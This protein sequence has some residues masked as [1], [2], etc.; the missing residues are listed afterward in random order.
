MGPTSPSPQ[1]SN[2]EILKNVSARD[3]QTGDNTQIIN[4]YNY[5]APPPLLTSTPSNIP[6]LGA[7]TFVGRR[8]E[9]EQIHHLLQ[10]DMQVAVSAIAGMGGVGKTELAVQYTRIYRNDYSAGQGWFSARTADVGAQILNFAGSLQL[11][12]PEQLDSVERI[13]YVWQH[14]PVCPVT[15]SNKKEPGDVL[16]V[17]DDVENYEQVRPYL[18]LGLPRFK[19][20]ITSRN[21]LGRNVRH[22]PLGVLS[23]ELALELLESFISSQRVETEKQSAKELCAWLGCLPLGIELVGQYLADRKAITLAN[24]LEQLKV[25]KLSEASLQRDEQDPENSSFTA[26]RG[27]AAAFELSWNA[28]NDEQK[29]LGCLLSLFAPAAIGWS[30]VEKVVEQS[31]EQRI[32]NAESQEEAR[33]RLVKSHLLQSAEDGQSFR[34]HPLLR[35]FFQE[36]LESPEEVD[37]LKQAYC[38]VL[39]GEA[40]QIPARPTREFV[41]GVL[42]VIP[43]LA[44]AATT[45]L[46]WVED[47]NLIWPFIGLGRFYAGQGAY[48]QA[49]TWFEQCL[50]VCRKR[51]RKEHPDVAAS[52]NNL[53]E[54][55]RNQGRY[56]QAEQRFKEALDIWEKVLGPEHPDV[57]CSLNNLAELYRE[58]GRYE[59]AESL[60]KRAL[61][62]LKKV[63]RPD[64]LDVASSLNNLAVLYRH[65]GHFEQAKQR[66]EEALDIRKKVLGLEHSLVASS[67]NNLAE[68]YSDQGRYEQAKQRFK[69][70][71]DIRKKV[72][73]PEHPHVAS[74]L[75]NLAELYRDQGRYEQAERLHKK[76][77]DIV[78]KVLGPE[79]HDVACSLNNLAALYREQGR[80][81]KAEPLYKRALAIVEKRLGLE[82]PDVASSLNNLALLYE[83]QGCYG[84][85]EPFYNRA[86]AIWEKLLGL[87]HPNV[88]ISLNNMAN[89]YYSQDKY[90]K[91]EPLYSQALAILVNRLGSDHPNTVIAWQ[92]YMTFLETVVQQP[93][94]LKH[95]LPASSPM[96]QHLL[97]EIREG[98]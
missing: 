78:E 72:L 34:L 13:A 54:L 15:T 26:R 12:P 33:I 52:L 94:V 44:E 79:H 81:E 45:L 19:V 8:E 82:H 71:L 37:K 1:E 80:Y 40:Q 25:Q 96:T 73:G 28:L 84:Q 57:A 20:L 70:A 47:E 32:L 53:A 63:P 35:E 89:F 6:Y 61:D 41:E 46:P 49:Q 76:A 14:W 64:D 98:L 29:E 58:Q 56:E 65:Q 42:P 39:V 50:V 75:N 59:Q 17:F 11:V 90:E 60:H 92:N 88:S 93:V 38:R 3:I 97:K 18:P 62:I 87:E 86:L 21:E 27:V 7:S 2:Q 22:I 43:H 95:L 51:L 91:A 77:L 67:L 36:K 74:S 66:F 83:N 48:A 10:Q 16:L 23:P 85:A 55:Y 30:L 5:S 9:L 68:L 24:L 4:N 31:R 69:E